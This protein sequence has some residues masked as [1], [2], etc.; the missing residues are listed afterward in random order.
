MTFDPGLLLEEI[1]FQASRSGGKG[2][3]N[4]NKVSSRVELLFDVKNSVHLSERQKKLIETKLAS[5]I[6]AEGVLR[7]VSQEARMQTANKKNAVEKF[8]LLIG[9][10]LKERKKRIPTRIP[11]ALKEERLKQKRQVSEKKIRRQK[12][13][14]E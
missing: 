11:E 3:Q 12:T 1:S 10:C 6:N 5:R 2:G 14:E 8:I 4:V 7:I 9:R 13:A